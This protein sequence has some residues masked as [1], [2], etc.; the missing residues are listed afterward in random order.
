MR[1]NGSDIN[2]VAPTELIGF[3]DKM[4]SKRLAESHLQGKLVSIY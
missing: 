4:L 2:S 3:M 1:E